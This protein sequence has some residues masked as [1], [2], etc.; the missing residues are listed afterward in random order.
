MIFRLISIVNNFFLKPL[1]RQE[2]SHKELLFRRSGSQKVRS[3]GSRVVKQTGRVTNPFFCLFQMSER[4]RE[5]ISIF[6]FLAG[7]CNVR[8]LKKIFNLEQRLFCVK[9]ACVQWN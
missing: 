3:S 5:I 1:L 4:K 7:F 8:F 2:K 6:R 9:V